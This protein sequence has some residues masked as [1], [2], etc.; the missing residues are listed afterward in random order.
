MFDLTMYLWAYF[1]FSDVFPY[2]IYMLV[3]EQTSKALAR[4]EWVIEKR[5][6]LKI[7]QKNDKKYTYI[8]FSIPI[9]SG[10]IAG[11]FILLYLNTEVRLFVFF[12]HFISLFCFLSTK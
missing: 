4:S 12:I 11:L 6:Q 8:D 3:Y 10:A 7:L 9:L 2:G 5:K 1:H